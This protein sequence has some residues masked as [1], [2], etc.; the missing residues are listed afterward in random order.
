M[1]REMNA[2]CMIVSSSRTRV[3]CQVCDS[4]PS[5]LSCLQASRKHLYERTSTS[6]RM[7][8]VG[9]VAGALALLV[10]LTAHAQLGGPFDTVGHTMRDLGTTTSGT[11]CGAMVD[12]CWD[13]P[14]CNACNSVASDALEG[15]LAS[16]VDE[17]Y[18]SASISLFSCSD[19]AEVRCCQVEAAEDDADC[20]SNALWVAIYGG[21]RA[22]CHLIFGGV[23]FTLSR[24][25]H[26]SLCCHVP[27]LLLVG[28]TI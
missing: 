14:V 21:L 4:Q 27:E 12:S 23:T 20:A 6:A 26:I 10:G 19:A 15:C 7:S 1:D 28:E 8:R 18:L 13:D 16:N 22:W 9:A 5:V 3:G 2:A 11:A 24:C 17:S 25:L